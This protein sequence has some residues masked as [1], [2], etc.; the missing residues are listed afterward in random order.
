MLTDFRHPMFV[1][2]AVKYLDV[3]GLL[4]SVPATNPVWLADDA[5]AAELGARPGLRIDVG[6][7]AGRMDRAIDW[8]LR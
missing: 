3:P 2:G 4:A 7:P 8:L 1:P 5:A 6:P